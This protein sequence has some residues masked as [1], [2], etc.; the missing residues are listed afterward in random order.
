MPA[1]HKF[2][3][4]HNFPW[5]ALKVFPGVTESELLPA[6]FPLALFC[7]DGLSPR[8]VLAR[9]CVRFRVHSLRRRAHVH[10]GRIQVLRRRQ[11]VRRRFQR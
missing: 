9:S 4:P 8:S 2:T 10:T 6:T 11:S 3:E 7:F 1:F 5:R